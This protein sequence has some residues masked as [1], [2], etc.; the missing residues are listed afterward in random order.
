MNPPLILLAIGSTLLSVAVAYVCW[1]FARTAR[2]EL[3]TARLRIEMAKKIEAIGALDDHE[4]IETDARLKCLSR[5]PAHFSFPLWLI[6]LAADRPTEKVESDNPQVREVLDEINAKFVTQMN[7]Y[8]LF[9]TLTGL[10]AVSAVGV[11]YGAKVFR[12]LKADAEIR[13]G[14]AFHSFGRF[15]SGIPA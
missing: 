9:E 1:T 2:F 14:E 7:C 8:T 6:I 10:T 5:F 11:F 4:Y 13:S 15:G 3:A 12:K